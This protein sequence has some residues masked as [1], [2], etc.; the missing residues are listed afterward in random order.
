M[1]NQNDLQI[2]STTL[3]R[4][5]LL[6][7]VSAEL[8]LFTLNYHLN[9]M[10]LMGDS[11]IQRLFN[12]AREDSLPGWFNIIQTAMIAATL[13]LIYAVK[14]QRGT[15][16]QGRGWFA[17]ALFFSYL[18]FDDGAHIHE[19]VGTWFGNA[20][21]SM[22]IG[23]WL[24]DFF[25][26]YRWQIV[27][28]PIFATMGVFTFVFMLKEL[29]DWKPKLTVFVAMS[30]LALAVTA[31]FFEGLSQTHALNPY[32]WLAQN[33]HID[34]WTNRTLGMS[35]YDTLIHFSRSIEEC[36]EMFA[37]TLLWTVFLSHLFQSLDGL[38][39]KVVSPAANGAEA[40]QPA[41]LVRPATAF[42]TPSRA[43]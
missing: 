39:M 38:R 29:R 24:L 2:D 13:W 15:K 16:W 22:V 23:A 25:P 20:G 5:M 35:L 8:L 26:S 43:A 28:M 41:R 27:F 6:V 32:T 37:M 17:I 18:A 42:D 30:F 33:W 36:L 21:D 31:D 9:L 4:N 11:A 10:N 14:R 34:Y 12:T 1:R 19:R 3:V 40:D 7:L